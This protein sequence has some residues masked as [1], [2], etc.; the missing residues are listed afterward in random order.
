MRPPDYY[1]FRQLHAVVFA[2]PYDEYP[3]A[4]KFYLRLHSY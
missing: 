4:Q 1:L 3:E 2:L